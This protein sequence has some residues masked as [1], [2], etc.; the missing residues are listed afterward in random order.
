MEEVFHEFSMC[1]QNKFIAVQKGRVKT[2]G[3]KKT[4][5]PGRSNIVAQSKRSGSPC[6][7]NERCTV[8]AD[9]VTQIRAVSLDWLLELE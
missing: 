6:H 1:G 8:Q 4:E 5:K 7:N 9:S 2:N 3:K